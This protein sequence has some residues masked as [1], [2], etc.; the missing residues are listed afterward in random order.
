MTFSDLP[1][2]SLWNFR[3]SAV[4]FNDRT[5]YLNYTVKLE[6]LEFPDRVIHVASGASFEEAFFVAAGLFWD[7]YRSR[8]MDMEVRRE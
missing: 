1:L 6:C 8:K 4:R 5:A 2:Q 3:F 7:W